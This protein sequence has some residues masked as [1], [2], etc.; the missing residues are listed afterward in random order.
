MVSGERGLKPYNASNWVHPMLMWYELARSVRPWVSGWYA[1]EVLSLE[2]QSSMRWKSVVAENEAEVQL[3]KVVGLGLL[4]VVASH[5][6]HADLTREVAEGPQSQRPPKST[7]A[8]GCGRVG[9]CPPGRGCAA[10][11]LDTTCTMCSSRGRRD[12]WQASSRPPTGLRTSCRHRGVPTPG[13]RGLP[14]GASGG[15]VAGPRSAGLLSPSRSRC[16]LA[17]WRIESGPGRAG[18]CWSGEAGASSDRRGLASAHQPGAQQEGGTELIQERSEVQTAGKR[19]RDDVVLPLDVEDLG[20]VELGEELLPASEAGRERHGGLSMDVLQRLV[21]GVDLDRHAGEVVTPHLERCLNRQELLL[22]GGVVDF[23]VN[24]LAGVKRHCSKSASVSSI[25]HQRGSKCELAR[26]RDEHVLG[27]RVVG[28]EYGGTGQR[29]LEVVERLV[30]LG[31]PGEGRALLEQ[32]K[33]RKTDACVAFHI[34]SIVV[35]QA[36]EGSELVD[37]EQRRPVSYGVHL[38]RVHADSLGGDNAPEEFHL[39]SKEL[40]LGELHRQ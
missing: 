40:T 38:G 29:R 14:R 22:P 32:R 4:N 16:Q 12:A 7:P 35:G 36:D 27:V 11:W 9:R 5:R 37:V 28:L 3:H 13:S 1:V 2:P 19:V 17:R 20:E 23:S 24:V 15:R 25:L 8:P 10:C 39:L 30:V 21:V 6:Q 31:G 26:V 18:W 33:E 34:A